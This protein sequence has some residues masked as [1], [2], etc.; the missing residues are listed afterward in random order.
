MTNVPACCAKENVPADGEAAYGWLIGA[1]GG[2]GRDGFDIHVFASILALSLAEARRAGETL[3]ARCGLGGAELAMLARDMFP[4]AAGDL[5]DSAGEAEADVDAE[6][7]SVRDIL[8]MYA[9]GASDLE[10]PLAA[11]IARRC[12]EPHH[13]WQDL[14][15]NDRS[16]LSR[17]MVRHFAPLKARNSADMKWKKFLYRMVCSSEGFTLC[18]APVRSD[19]DDFE[20]CFGDEDGE[21]RL[22]RAGNPRGEAVA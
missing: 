6:E 11:M 17:L 12:K 3:A 22:L 15:L 1:S 21:A 14:G 16:E 4:G 20:V 9:S 2:S 19:C 13:L 5:A 8:L 18:T 10:R 7:Q